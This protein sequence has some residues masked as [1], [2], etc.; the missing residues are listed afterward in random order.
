MPP[1]EN[2]KEVL[3]TITKGNGQIDKPLKDFTENKAEDQSQDS[4]QKIKIELPPLRF[5][6][7]KE[8]KMYEEIKAK[9]YQ[10]LQ[11]E[12]KRIAEQKGFDL[13]QSTGIK[14]GKYAYFTCSY[15]QESSQI[16]EC[17][18]SQEI[19]TKNTKESKSFNVCYFNLN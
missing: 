3:Q 7:N 12:L 6:P 1:T 15:K 8:S 14:S 13:A 4:N 10:M 2:S 5:D 9:D 11:R 19:G 18:E 16:N 17:N